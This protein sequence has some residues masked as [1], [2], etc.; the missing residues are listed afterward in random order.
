MVAAVAIVIVVV[1]AV[2]GY[3]PTAPGSPLPSGVA[4]ASDR[5]PTPRESATVTPIPPSTSVGAS[6]SFASAAGRPNIVLIYLDDVAPHDGRLWN[7]PARTPNLQEQ[8]VSHG[9]TFENAIGETPLCCPGRVDML[10]GL[11]GHNSG[12]TRNFAPMFDPSMHIGKQR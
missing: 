3:P 9:V 1:A 10:T 6:P 5:R 12:V 4:T 7:D 8:F 11:H 2:A